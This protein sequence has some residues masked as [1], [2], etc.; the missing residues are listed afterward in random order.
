M[1][2]I[3][4]VNAVR[5]RRLT[6]PGSREGRRRLRGTGRWHRAGVR[7]IHATAATLAEHWRH[8]PPRRRLPVPDRSAKDVNVYPS[9]VEKVLLTHPAVRESAV[10]GVPDPEWGESVRALAADDP[11]PGELSQW[12]RAR[13]ASFKKPREVIF[14]TDLPKNAAGKIP[15]RELC[16]LPS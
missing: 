16:Q 2:H 7:D 13:L 6:P 10:A 3:Q 12:C 5:L 8:R 1:I 4:R 15:K 9:K 11:T 14:V